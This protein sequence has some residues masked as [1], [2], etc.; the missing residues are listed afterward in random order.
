MIARV[1]KQETVLVKD[2]NVNKFYYANE[3]RDGDAPDFNVM[4]SSCLFLHMMLV[5]ISSKS[6]EKKP[7]MWIDAVISLYVWG[8]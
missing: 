6:A 4:V 5:K 3:L 1:F 8:I 7:A 2:F